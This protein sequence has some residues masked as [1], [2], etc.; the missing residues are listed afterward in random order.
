MLLDDFDPE[1]VFLLTERAQ[2]QRNLLEKALRAIDENIA[3]R[4]ADT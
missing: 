1:K 4:K 2:A 3:R